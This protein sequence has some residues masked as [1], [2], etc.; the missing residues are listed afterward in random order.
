MGAGGT[1]LSVGAKAPIAFIISEPFMSVE[2]DLH[3]W[4]D[5]WQEILKSSSTY[6][7]KRRILQNIVLHF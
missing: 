4:Q 3:S 1:A 6:R 7:E 2:L 5:S